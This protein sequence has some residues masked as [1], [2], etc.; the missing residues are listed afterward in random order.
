M[1]VTDTPETPQ[2]E[3]RR[4][5]YE[6][7]PEET[8]PV[9]TP[10]PVETPVESEE[11]EGRIDEEL[12]ARIMARREQRQKEAVSKF[13]RLDTK[14]QIGDVGREELSR[15]IRARRQPVV[16]K[17]AGTRP[18]VINQ[19]TEQWK[20]WI[21]E[22]ANPLLLKATQTW[23]QIPDR[24]LDDK[25]LSAIDPNTNKALVF[26]DPPLRS[27]LE[28]SE[29]K[30]KTLAKAAAEFSVSPMGVAIVTWVETHQFII[31]V[32]AAM[33]VAA[34]YGW[35]LMQTKAEVAQVRNIVE[36]Q[37]L[38]QMQ[39]QAMAEN[40]MANGSAVRYP[41]FGETTNDYDAEQ[42]S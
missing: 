26:W 8:P 10:E 35:T 15:Q 27:R 29:K 25:I 17:A 23:C 37:Q 28:L 2:E 21:I 4:S 20:T 16:N 1:S 22:D 11:P 14:V 19:R 13:E 7:E 40:G 41:N 38:A 9:E 3:P 6:A 39:Q 31:S 12:R 18:E 24:W 33:V 36:Q 32:G 42:N 30:A 34:Q 5:I